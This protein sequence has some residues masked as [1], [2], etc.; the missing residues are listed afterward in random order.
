M[1]AQKGDVLLCWSWSWRITF[2]RRLPMAGPLA[3]GHCPHSHTTPQGLYQCQYGFNLLHDVLSYTATSPV[4]FM[5]YHWISGPLC[6]SLSYV[7]LERLAQT[8]SYTGPTI[9]MLR[10]LA[11][12]VA[13]FG[14]ID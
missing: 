13:T 6:H 1:P 14:L 5:Y 10:Y 12:T 7:E 4:E 11:L 9:S 3:I 8:A 2:A